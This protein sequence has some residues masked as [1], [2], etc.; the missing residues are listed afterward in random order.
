MTILN[1]LE[2][3]AK[4]MDQITIAL[5]EANKSISV[6]YMNKSQNNISGYFQVKNSDGLV[7]YGGFFE[8]VDIVS[9]NSFKHRVLENSL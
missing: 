8:A 4:V 2:P 9:L 6:Y 5:E 1:L 3:F 7:N